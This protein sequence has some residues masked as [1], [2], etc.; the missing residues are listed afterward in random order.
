MAVSAELST[1]RVPAT[2]KSIQSKVPAGMELYD[3]PL[4]TVGMDTKKAIKDSK[5]I[6]CEV[7]LSI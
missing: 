5:E 4:S 3:A 6:L 7:I 1:S 2:G